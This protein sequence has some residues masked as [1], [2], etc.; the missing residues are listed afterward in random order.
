[1]E[2]RVKNLIIGAGPSGLAMAGRLAEKGQPFTIL[3]KGTQVGEAWHHHYERLHLHTDRKFS[4]LPHRPIPA[5]APTFLPRLDLIK[6]WEEYASLYGIQPLFDQEVVNIRREGSV[7][8]TTTKTDQ[9]VSDTVTVCTGYNRIP[10]IPHWPGEERFKGT[11]LHSANYK[12]AT[13][14][15]NRKVLVVG[16]GNSGAEIALDRRNVYFTP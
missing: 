10:T 3:E 11:I 13:P 15:K 2:Q 7:W 4:G 1:M 12:N 14:F 16:M 6:Y 9:F 8:V 5:S